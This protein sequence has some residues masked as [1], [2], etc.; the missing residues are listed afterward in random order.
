MVAV[1][2][3]WPDDVTDDDGDDES[4]VAMIEDTEEAWSAGSPGADRVT[5]YDRRFTG[6]R[7]RVRADSS[8][9]KRLPHERPDEADLSE[10]AL[11]VLRPVADAQ[12]SV[13]VQE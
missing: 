8:A 2:C 1:Y 6:L 3:D 11:R 9:A 7:R 10:A 13:E 4:E 5:I 12:V